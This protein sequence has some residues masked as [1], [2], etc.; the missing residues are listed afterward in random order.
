MV[1]STGPIDRDKVRLRGLYP[2]IAI[3]FAMLSIVFVVLLNAG[4]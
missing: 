4:V 1:A 3:A 2:V